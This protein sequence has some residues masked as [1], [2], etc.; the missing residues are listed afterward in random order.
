MREVG[1][2]ES[3]LHTDPY[4]YGD[5]QLL[6]GLLQLIGGGR[7]QLDSGQLDCAVPPLLFTIPEKKEVQICIAQRTS[8]SGY[9]QTRELSIE[10]PLIPNNLMIECTRAL[11]YSR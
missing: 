3:L 1:P 2:Y 8:A 6:I 4:R 5:E 7:N 11:R 9:I 10:V